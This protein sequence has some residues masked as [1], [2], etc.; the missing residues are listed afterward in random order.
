MRDEGEVATRHETKA[1]RDKEATRR[2]GKKKGCACER[3]ISE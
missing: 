2:R 3:E 1:T